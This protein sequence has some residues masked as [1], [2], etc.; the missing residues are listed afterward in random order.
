MLSAVTGICKSVGMKA[1]V[2]FSGIPTTSLEAVQPWYESHFGRPPDVVANDHEV[3]WQVLNGGWPYV[4][5]DKAHAGHAL[6]A[7]AVSDLGQV[8]DELAKRGI[9]RPKVETN[10]RR[11]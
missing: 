9:E 3:V 4:V 2:L 11:W 1:E 10:S 5:E 6:V 7:V 8:L